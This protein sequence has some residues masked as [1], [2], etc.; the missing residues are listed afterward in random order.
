MLRRGAGNPIRVGSYAGAVLAGQVDD[1]A[2]RAKR[3]RRLIRIALALAI[4]VI[5]VVLIAPHVTS[6][7][8]EL[9]HLR[10]GWIFAAIGAQAVSVLTFAWLRCALL[11]VGGVRVSLGRM[12]ALT[13]AGSAITVTVPAGSMISLGYLYQHLRRYRAS[14][15]L[16]G[17][18]FTASAIVSAL[19][20]TMVT[21]IGTVLSG[22]TSLGA[23]LSAGGLSL[24]AVIGLSALLTVITRHPRPLVA[25]VRWLFRRLPVLRKRV[26]TDDVF[27]RAVAQ[28]TAITPRMRDWA[29]AFW[30]SALNWL[31]D[32]VCFI[33]C[34]YAV[35]VDHLDLNLVVLA[36]GAGLA[37]TSISLLPAGLG[38]VDASLL[39]GL[40]RAG[41]AT[42]LALAAII[43]YRLV[44]YVLFALFGWVAWA[45]L[46]RQQ[47]APPDHN[48]EHDPEQPLDSGQAAARVSV[49]A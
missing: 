47:P 37:T 44:A 3:S 2:I 26:A 23:L 24:L 12:S 27:E 28:F 20:L 40:T 29:T 5:E 32:L 45:A 48:P 21:L 4:L 33:F 41:V 1:A 42:P 49:A 15:P 11:N 17:W 6:S 14:A 46:R 22:H 8:H 43:T 36:Y 18:L 35:G 25:V 9:R 31:A 38:S 19:A 13:M 10:W 16:I 34:C 7:G 30:C 39:V